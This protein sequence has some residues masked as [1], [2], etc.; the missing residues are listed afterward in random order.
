MS[1][2]KTPEQAAEE[3]TL[4]RDAPVELPYSKRT[5]CNA[6]VKEQKAAFV[7]GDASGATRE[8]ERIWEAIDTDYQ[9][10]HP[11]KRLKQIIFGG[12]DE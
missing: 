6:I 9:Y 5:I 2:D 10:T 4:T 7:A 3:W 8:R 12:G 1:D 11:L